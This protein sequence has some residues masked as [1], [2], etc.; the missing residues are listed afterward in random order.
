M[1]ASGSLV[2]YWELEKLSGKD[3]GMCHP[4]V[5]ELVEP[6]LHQRLMT[7]EHNRIEFEYEKK[8]LS[9]SELVERV[10]NSPGPRLLIMNTV[11]DAAVLAADICEKFGR[12]R[13]EH[14][15]TA[16]T[17]ED[18]DKTIERIRLRLDNKSDTDW[19]LVATSCVEAGVDFSFRT[20]FREIFSL[21]SLLQAAGR[22]NRHG[23][24]DDAAILSFSMQDDSML[25]KNMGMGGS[26]AVLDDYFKKKVP[27]VPEL[28]TRSMNDELNRDDN[29]LEEIQSL[30]TSESH[31]QFQTIEKQFNVIESDTVTVVTDASLAEA[32]ADGEGDWRE[33]QKKSVSV[34][35]CKI[36][37]WKLEETACGVYRWTLK[38]DDFLGYMS[39]VLSCGLK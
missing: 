7:Y 13:V 26:A 30:M 33:L 24:Y 3:I 28:S 21:L 35:S 19:T 20:G 11:R 39:G 6:S 12:E 16:L 23:R 18:R 9:R 34:R 5:S 29:C 25:S 36:K 17:P 37:P 14:L 22:V 38:Y 32:I 10:H 8:P 15:S 27:I 2:R 1:L 31:M 4:E